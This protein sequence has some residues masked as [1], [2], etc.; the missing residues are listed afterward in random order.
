MS[1]E[2]LINSSNFS[3]DSLLSI[4][5]AIN[6]IVGLFNNST[7]FKLIL[8]TS[9]MLALNFINDNEVNP[10]EYKL[11]VTPKFS[12]YAYSNT[13]SSNFF[14]ISFAG[15]TFS[16]SNFGSGN[17]LMLILPFGVRGSPSICINA[18]GTI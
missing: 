5:L 2:D 16:K 8:N 18:V 6:L 3:S 1:F 13:I 17:A 11:S 15:E 14:S 9:E 12:S 7:I 10:R 4:K